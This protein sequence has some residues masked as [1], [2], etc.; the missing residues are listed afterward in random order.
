MFLPSYYAIKFDFYNGER[1]ISNNYK[2]NSLENSIGLLVGT[3]TF[4]R[5]FTFSYK[6]FPTNHFPLS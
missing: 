5:N 2:N 3:S 4:K 1:D 6:S